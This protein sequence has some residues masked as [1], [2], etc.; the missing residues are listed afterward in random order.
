MKS[1]PDL[2]LVKYV[3]VESYLTETP[4]ADRPADQIVSRGRM[5]RPVT[6]VAGIDP[7]LTRLKTFAD[8]FPHFQWIR[9]AMLRLFSDTQCSLSHAQ[10]RMP[11][12]ASQQAIAIQGKRRVLW[13]SA[14][15]VKL[16]MK[17]YQS[18]RQ[19][20]S[21]PGSDGSLKFTCAQLRTDLRVNDNTNALQGRMSI[22]ECRK[23][24]HSARVKQV[25][26]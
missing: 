18:I 14:T 13:G 21:K 24:F 17:Q 15:R 2:W 25:L 11:R 9:L 6:P 8:S 5:A 10:S 4:F 3:L 12:S 20:V 22:L 1:A 26:A 19:D 7:Y 23:H 16:N